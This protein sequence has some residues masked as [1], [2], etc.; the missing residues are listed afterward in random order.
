MVV[1]PG[2]RVFVG[3]VVTGKITATLPV[4]KQSWGQRINGPGT[5]QAT[6]PA[7][8][9]EYRNLSLSAATEPKRQFLGIAYGDQILEC[10]PIWK[11]RYRRATGKTELIGAG[12]WSLLDKTKALNWAQISAGVA[13]TRTGIDLTGLSRGS[14][15][16]ELIR[17]SIETNPNNPGLPIVLP[18]LVAGTHER[19]YEGYKLPWLGDLLKKLTESQGGPDIALRP[20][21]KPSDPTYV[22][23]VLMHGTEADPILHQTGADWPWDG[24]VEGSGVSVFDTDDDATGMADRVWQPGAGSEV[25][26]KLATAASTE[27]IGRAGYPW[28]EQD[29]ASKDI[30]DAGILQDL[31]DAGLAAGSRPVESWGVQVRAELAPKLGTYNPG[32]FAQIT[33]ARGHPFIPA[34]KR[35]VRIMAID[36]DG[37][38]NVK[39]TPAPLASQLGGT[40]YGESLTSL[41]P[42]QLI[43]PGAGLFPGPT[44]HT[45]IG[46]SRTEL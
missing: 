11:R 13:V 30:E 2:F 17:I 45:G 16:R 14:I 19:H 39:L 22:E 24:T 15:A 44:T 43:Y 5:V 38:L 41:D 3:E 4:E 33:V 12:L 8:A 37:S 35:R 23:W 20:R 46:Y 7:T 28:T 29:S 9:K 26:M 6:L 1:S 21:F 31:A 34:G 25:D 27:L 36:G 42:S 18:P 32:D 40:G 10:G